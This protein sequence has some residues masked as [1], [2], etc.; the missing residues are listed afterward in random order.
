MNFP[1][2]YTLLMLC[3]WYSE[4]KPAQPLLTFNNET[5]MFE[6]NK[7]LLLE[8]AE[9]QRPIQVIA[10]VGDA[11]IGKS[12]TL[13]LINHIWSGANQTYIEEVFK[14]GDTMLPVTRDVWAQVIQPRDEQGGN[15]V[16]LDVEGTNLG[17]DALTTHLSMFTAL[18][19]SGLNLFVREMVQNN[20]L[21]FLFHMSRLS[22]LVFPNISLENFPKLQVVI[23]QG[24]L[25]DPG[26]GKTIEDYTRDSIVEPSFQKNMKDERQIIAKHFP[27]NQI[28]VVQIPYLQERERGFLSDFEKLSTL[29]YWGVM[30][31]LVEKL[32]Q[33][34]VKKTLGGSY[35]DGQALVELAVRLTETMNKNSWPDFGSVYDTIEKNICSRSYIKFVEPLFAELTADIIEAKLEDTLRAFKMECILENEIAAARND[36]QRIVEEKRKVEELERKT[37]EAESERVA[38]EKRREEQEKKFQHELTIKEDQIAE[39][40]RE[41]E[42]AQLKEKN[43]KQLHEEQLKTIA[44]L[45]EQM[46]RRNRGSLSGIVSSIIG[47]VLGAA[48]FSDRDLKRNITTL[49]HSPYSVIKLEGACWEWNEISEKTFGLTGEECGVIAQEVKKLYPFAVTRGKDGYLMVRYGL[50][51]EMMDSHLQ[52]TSQERQSRIN[53]PDKSLF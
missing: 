21:H 53:K 45:Q 25:K 40:K 33:F 2:F 48:F 1:L 39:V 26:E 44:L 43:L 29:Q 23:R 9:L 8:I 47:G 12:T 42:A 32:K 7:D 51:H 4:G 19:S 38:A 50:L 24:S 22:D 34:P 36:V 18:I 3:A 28:S 14:T 16:L 31:R 10:V 49:P 41:K 17:D 20:N 27:R 5:E 11:R 35:I 30:E 6:L 52:S 46:R 15:V 37:K 13:N